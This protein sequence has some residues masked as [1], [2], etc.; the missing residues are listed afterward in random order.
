MRLFAGMTR[1][2][3]PELGIATCAFAPAPPSLTAASTDVLLPAIQTGTVT[4]HIGPSL[5][6]TVQD[7]LN[8]E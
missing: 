3:G 2:G 7:K 6:G 1:P 4:A 5:A 8:R